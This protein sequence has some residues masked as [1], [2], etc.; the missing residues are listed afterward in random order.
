VRLLAALIAALALAGT[1]DGR[2]R[3]DGAAARDPHRHCVKHVKTVTPTPDEAAI[4]PNIACTR[5][6]VGDMAASCA[7]GVPAEQA[8]ATVAMLGDSHAAH[9]RATMEAVALKQKWRVLEIARPHCPFSFASPAPTEAGASDC[10][11]WNQRII[12]WLAANPAVGTVFISNNARLPM[13]QRDF[14][15]RLNGFLGAFQAL[16]ASVTR[17]FVLRDPPTDRASS[18]DCVTRAVKHHWAPGRHCAVPRS[19]ALVRDAGISAAEQL[20][21]RLET[22]DLTRFFCDRKHCFPVVGGV[23]VHKDVDHL[24]QDFAATL[25]PYLLRAIGG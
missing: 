24:T 23:L 12:D 1:A 7:V 21:G 17:A 11:A 15:Y 4:T 20:K 5:G 19:R 9:W 25:G 8:V 16:P 22:V 18:H 2:P 10:V 3:C 6:E 13:A 14:A